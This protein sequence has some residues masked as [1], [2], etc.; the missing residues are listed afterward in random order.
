ML[1]FVGNS[2]SRVA[3]YKLFLAWI[4][5]A[6]LGTYS[7]AISIYE[8]Y[9]GGI[10]AKLISK[11]YNYSVA[12]DNSTSRIAI[13]AFPRD[14]YANTKM[15]AV[16]MIFCGSSGLIALVVSIYFMYYNRRINGM[17]YNLLSV[18][19]IVILLPFCYSAFLT[20]KLHDLT[21]DDITAWNSINGEFIENL[22]RSQNLLIATVIPGFTWCVALCMACVSGLIRDLE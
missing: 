10:A 13:D 2:R 1:A 19:F 7:I 4:F 9:V 15:S 20:W 8:C 14:I 11:Y 6:M 21:I 22:E 3:N 16:I 18:N 17:I 12:I 5:I